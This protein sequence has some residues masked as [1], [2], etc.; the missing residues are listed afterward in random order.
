MSPVLKTGYVRELA[1]PLR[2]VAFRRLWFGLTLSR[3]GDQFTLIA[4]LWFVLIVTDSGAA[5]GLVVLCLRL[6]PLV[7]G[8]VIGRL[9]N[10]YQPRLVMAVDNAL[11]A[12]IIG[13]IPAL[14]FVDALS[15]SALYVLAVLAGAL[16]PATE[17][18]IRT[19][20]PNLVEDEKLESANA[21]SSFTWEFAAL[22]GPGLAGFMVDAVGG[23]VTLLVDSMSF[24]LMSVVAMALP[25]TSL[26]KVGTRR[27]SAH[28]WLGF[29]LLW[30]FKSVR[31]IT[32]LTVLFFFAYGPL[33]VALPVYSRESLAGSA[34]TL[35]LLWSAFGLGS[36]LGLLLAAEVA[37]R[38]RPGVVLATI[39]LCWG[40]LT[41][42]LVVVESTLV[43]MGLLFLAGFVWAPYNVIDVSL[44]QRL[45]PAHLRGEVFGARSTLGAAGSPLG[46]ALGGLLLGYVSGSVLISLSAAL[47]VA[48][49]MWGLSSRTV[50]SIRTPHSSS[51][52]KETVDGTRC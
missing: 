9:M 51:A 14:H 33:E 5:V 10:R 29:G 37:R 44:M 38:F 27:S 41:L 30:S 17:I 52:R 36:I 6:P 21:L 3:L 19:I 32:A 28:T 47:C 8:P 24:I 13:S 11:R 12:V 31:F 50:R 34:S 20:L 7:T 22:I 40:L 18:G 42:P 46:A 26:S 4:L 48:V 15:L 35:G 39:A 25:R 2:Y 1:S 45:I 16:T 49:G 23:P 43:A